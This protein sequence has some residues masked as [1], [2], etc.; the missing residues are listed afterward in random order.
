MARW[1]HR[2]FK[3]ALIALVF[4]GVEL[5]ARFMLPDYYRT[6]RGILLGAEDQALVRVQNTIGQAYL[7]Y[8]C[9]PNYMHPK[10]GRQHNEDGYRGKAVPLD[11]R[12]G[13][14]RVLCLGGSTT[15]G[16]TVAYP[17][18]TYPAVL[19][20]L[21]RANPPKGY[22]DV[23]VLNGGLPW[24]TSAE[25]LTHYHFKYHYYRPDIVIVNEG[26][27]DAQGYTLPYY[28]PDF[29]NWRQPM[30]NL[31]PLPR[32][33]RWLAHSQVAGALILNMFYSDQ[34]YGQQFYIKGG[35]RP[36]APWFKIDGK[37]V[38]DSARIPDD[39]LAF[40][41]NVEALVREILADGARV[42]LVPF[43]AAPGAYEKHGDNYELSQILRHERIFKDLAAKYSLGFAPY[44][45]ETISP[46]N[47]V[48]HCHVNAA[49]EAQKAAHI[50]PYVRALLAAPANSA[51]GP[52]R[53]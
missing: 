8:I 42:L 3:I 16:W 20:E 34:L 26:G 21:M 4:F 48:D 33:I 6:A 17:H 10:Y 46:T 14:L 52:G 22:R 51:A 23:E 15:Y 7:L 18:Q 1:K 11:R 39:K 38:E 29:S 43:R 2:L 13:T 30:V 45:A 5:V 25:M 9:A 40:S 27:N 12:P 36:L 53:Q 32:A 31:R 47:W 50:E 44:P 19:E 28:H 41:H 49:G 24:G 35:A 37:W